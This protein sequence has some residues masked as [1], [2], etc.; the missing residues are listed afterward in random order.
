MALEIKR[1]PVAGILTADRRLY[2]TADRRR[3]VEEG[4]TEA[5]FL[6]AAP[7]SEI[8]VDE[9][10]RLDLGLEDGRVIQRGALFP[11]PAEPEPKMGRP[12]HR[13]YGK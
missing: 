7:G 2:L 6:L 13:K 8:S 9:V 3:M 5:A 12:K 10:H 4:S 11:A 1:G